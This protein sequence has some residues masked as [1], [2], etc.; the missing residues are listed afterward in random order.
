M[1]LAH[2]RPGRDAD[3]DVC[4]VV[5][6]RLAH[7][8][9]PQLDRR[10]EGG[11][12]PPRLVLRVDGRPVH[13]DAHVSGKQLSRGDDHEAGD[14]E[15]G[16]GVAS[17]GNQGGRAQADEDRERADEVAPE[18]KCVREQ[19]VAVMA[20]ARTQGDDRPGRIDRDHEGDRSEGPPGRIDLH[21]DDSGEPRDCEAADHEA[22]GDEKARL[23]ERGE[24]LRLRVPEG[25]TAIGGPDGDRHREERHQRRGQV[26]PRVRRLR[27][28]AEAPARDSRD[29]LDRDQEAGGPD[30]DERGAP[31]RRHAR[32]ATASAGRR[33]QARRSGAP[34]SLSSPR[35]SKAMP[36]PRQ[37]E[38]RV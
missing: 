2:R 21:V 24:V 11:D 9:A 26:R 30:R 22:D 23:G 17:P 29:E 38:G 33:V 15:R 10:I 20:S 18:V 25:V 35:S 1:P 19:R 12:R 16:D 36:D 34:S 32:K 4:E 27:E 37:R 14:E 3:D 31:L 7:A 28:E 8:K 6:T 5:A 13:E